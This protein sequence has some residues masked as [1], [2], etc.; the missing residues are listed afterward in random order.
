MFAK[1]RLGLRVSSHPIRYVD[2]ISVT[3]QIPKTVPWASEENSY[4]QI[5]KTIHLQE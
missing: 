5:L 4:W 1:G 2:D 3:L